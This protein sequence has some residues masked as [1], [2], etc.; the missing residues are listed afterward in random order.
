MA[1]IGGLQVVADLECVIVDIVSVA[2]HPQCAASRVEERRAGPATGAVSALRG[3]TC[4]SPRR[5]RAA[6]APEPV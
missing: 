5:R 2:P 3:G 4:P 1:D 6:A